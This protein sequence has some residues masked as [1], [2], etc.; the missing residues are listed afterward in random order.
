VDIFYSHR[1]DPDTPLEETMGAL[2]S[3][4]RRGKALHVGISNYNPQQTRDA[5]HILNRL[6]TP[7]LIHQFPYS[8]FERNSEEGLQGVLEDEGVGSIAFQPLA[9]GLLTGKYLSGIPEGS[10]AAGPSEF[11][12]A[13]DI[14]RNRLDKI[15]SLNDIASRRGQSLAQMS[16]AWILKGGITSVLIGASRSEQIVE[17]VKALKNTHF[18]KEE[19]YEIDTISKA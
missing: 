10:R 18:T 14:T 6:G 7:C 19:L 12:N 11:L 15:R 8:I 5:I 3:A 13:E 2:D 4:V 9:Q 16:L 1:P 17:N